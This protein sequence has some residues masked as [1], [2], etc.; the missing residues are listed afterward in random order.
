MKACSIYKYDKKSTY[1]F[2]YPYNNS[3]ILFFFLNIW[4]DRKLTMN[5]TIKKIFARGVYTIPANKSSKASSTLSSSSSATL[6][7]P[8]CG[9]VALRIS[10]P[11]I[12]LGLPVDVFSFVFVRL[13]DD[14]FMLALVV[15]VVVFVLE[16]AVLLARGEIGETDNRS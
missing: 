14:D 1:F 16:A 5:Y 9:I 6:P 4:N 11:P 13:I 7:K 10:P 2:R 12:A 15:V 8:T 3:K